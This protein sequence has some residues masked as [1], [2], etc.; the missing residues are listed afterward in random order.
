MCVGGGVEAGE[1]KRYIGVWYM[2]IHRLHNTSTFLTCRHTTLY[3]HLTH[4][5]ILSCK[6]FLCQLVHCLFSL[7][8]A[9]H[10]QQCL[11]AG[12][13]IVG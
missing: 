12:C 11:P 13:L 1:E 10:L 5:T 4:F 6:D 2:Y 3:N 7:K 8:M 9:E